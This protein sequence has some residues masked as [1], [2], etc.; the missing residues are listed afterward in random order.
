MKHALRIA[1][2][3]HVLGAIALTTALATYSAFSSTTASPGNSFEAG[4]VYLGDNDLGTALVTLDQATPG[5]SATGCILVTYGGTLPSEVRLYA[6]V[7]GALAPYLQVR[8]RRGSDVAPSFPSCTGFVPDTTDYSGAGPG[9]IYS[10]TLAGLPST[11][12]GG[13]HDPALLGSDETWTASEQHSYEVEVTLAND[14][15]AAGLS[16]AADLHWEAR[17]L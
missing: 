3:V 16:A 6:T 11:F 8:I 10:G 12:A 9:V 2:S 7:S 1:A 15:A 4:S 5:D 14:P 13:I 17:N